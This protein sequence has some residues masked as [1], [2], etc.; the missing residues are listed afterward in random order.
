MNR[1][2]LHNSTV[3]SRMSVMC[4]ET[5]THVTKTMQK[6][7]YLYHKKMTNLLSF[8]TWEYKYFLENLTK[9]NTIMIGINEHV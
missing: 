1:Y 8:K 4:R 6:H 2:P 5:G 7:M 9:V 3:L